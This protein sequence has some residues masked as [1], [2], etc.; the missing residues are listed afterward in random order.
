MMSK[1][2]LL[3]STALAWTCAS[4]AWAQCTADA[5]TL[6]LNEGRFAVTADWQTGG[7][8]EAAQAELLTSDT[9]YF[10]FFN[11]A[12]VEMVVKVIDG[13]TVN[14]HFWV[15]A[16]GLTNVAVT[17]RVED[18]E[19]GAV[20]GYQNPANRAFQP[21][22]DTAAFT[23]CDGGGGGGGGGDPDGKPATL[24]PFESVDLYSGDSPL[25]I[26]IPTLFSIPTQRCWRGA[27]RGPE[28]W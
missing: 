17:L 1:T 11:A 21:I 19:T 12:N 2:V 10:W 24:P 26:P 4:P 27:S 20:Q 22:Q 13:C 28:R 25:N 3:L 5:H 7:P 15:F 14:Q 9:G 18:T 8:P 16:G 6:C 23:D